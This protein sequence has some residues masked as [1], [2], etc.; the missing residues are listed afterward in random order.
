M[1][2]FIYQHD[3]HR[4]GI[5]IIV[6]ITTTVI[7]VI[8]VIVVIVIK[9]ISVFTIV[10]IG[11]YRTAVL[12]RVTTRGWTSGAKGPSGLGGLIYIDT[13]CTTRRTRIRL[14]GTLFFAGEGFIILVF[15]S[16]SVSR[17]LLR[18]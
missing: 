15:T 5:F 6:V 12:R 10:V 14:L 17:C 9:I 4:H 1:G 11:G 16:L 8:I 3:H 18:R 13:H 7:I 2:F